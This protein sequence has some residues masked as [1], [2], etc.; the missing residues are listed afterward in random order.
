M[1]AAKGQRNHLWLNDSTKQKR[2]T[3]ELARKLTSKTLPPSICRWRCVRKCLSVPTLMFALIRV[4]IYFCLTRRRR[5]NVLLHH[6]ST[7]L[8]LQ[9]SK[10]FLSH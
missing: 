3:Y 7:K 9:I 6:I 10:P 4:F 1:N 8:L 5:V 2:R